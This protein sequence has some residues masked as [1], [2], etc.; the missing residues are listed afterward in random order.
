[1]NV[2]LEEDFFSYFPKWKGKVSIIIGGS[3]A[4]GHY[5]EYSDID[6][7]ILLST[8]RLKI[9]TREQIGKYKKRLFTLKEPIQLCSPETYDQLQAR[10]SDWSRDW[11]LRDFSQ[12]LI[13]QDADGRF[14]NI[15]KR[16]QRYPDAIRKEKLSWL[17][18]EA[19]FHLKE[20]FEIAIKRKDPFFIEITKLKIMRLFLNAY[21]I[22]LGRFP[23]FDKHLYFEIKCLPNAELI[24]TLTDRLIAERDPEKNYKDLKILRESIEIHLLKKKLIKKRSLQEWIDLRP[25]H[26]VEL[27]I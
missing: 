1:M 24:K 19:T 7:K 11:Y 23:S 13:V 21:V 27:E 20:R 25:T 26:R 12:A 2:F 8:Q 16:F 6:V 17:I 9:Y 10:L 3:V 4:H 14:R 5:D 22:S 15:Q 18:A